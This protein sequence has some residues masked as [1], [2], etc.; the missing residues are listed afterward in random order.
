M[1]RWE[2]EYDASG[3][4]VKS[5]YYDDGEDILS[6]WYEYSYDSQGNEVERRDYD[7]NDALEGIARREYRRGWE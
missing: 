1:W 4:K 7:E 2:Y 5:L 6:G 3:N